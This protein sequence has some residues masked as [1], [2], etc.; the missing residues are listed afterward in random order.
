MTNIRAL[1]PNIRLKESVIDLLTTQLAEAQTGRIVG[2]CGVVEYAN[3]TY[4]TIGSQT[5][6]RLQTAGALLEAA[7]KRLADDV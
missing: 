1:D 7:M 5:M 3:G 6:S 2:I 4:E